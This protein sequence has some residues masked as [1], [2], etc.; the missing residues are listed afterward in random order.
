MDFRPSNWEKVKQIERNGGRVWAESLQQ[1]LW[2]T[3]K[4]T[5]HDQ[6]CSGTGLEIGCDNLKEKNEET[7]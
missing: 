6:Q 1:A 3:G 5:L 4:T 2:Q 7:F